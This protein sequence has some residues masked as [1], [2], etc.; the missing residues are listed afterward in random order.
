V[1][2]PKNWL[3]TGSFE[4][5]RRAARLYLLVESCKLIDVSYLKDVLLTVAAHPQ[6]LIR[7][8]TPRDWTTTFGPH[9]S[10]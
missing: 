5:A 6:R 1:H 10:A 9:P 7:Q 8:L 2:N 3:F 4:G